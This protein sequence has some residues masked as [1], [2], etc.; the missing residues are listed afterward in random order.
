MCELGDGINRLKADNAALQREYDDL[1][2]Q[3]DKDVSVARGQASQALTLAR[4]ERD[5]R[6]ESA[7]QHTQ[8]CEAS[9]AAIE[10]SAHTTDEIVRALAALGSAFN[11]V[12]TLSQHPL[13]SY[14]STPAP[15]NFTTILASIR[16]QDVWTNGWLKTPK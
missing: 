12:Q 6:M 4:S 16:S 13:V 9:K 8:G 1:K 11:G 15:P 3:C 14:D 5:V 2:T 7:T 10:E